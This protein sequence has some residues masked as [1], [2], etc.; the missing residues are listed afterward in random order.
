V[1]AWAIFRLGVRL[2][3]RLFFGVSS[4]M[5][6]ILAIVFAGK[7]VAALQE[8]GKLPISVVD[9]PRLDLLGIYPNM[10]SL[11]L[12]ALLVVLALGGVTYTL[13]TARRAKQ[14]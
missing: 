14:G 3:L 1:L 6:Y 2:P 11:G 7:G 10:Q 9:L 5:L 8:A 12:Q 4:G 13:L